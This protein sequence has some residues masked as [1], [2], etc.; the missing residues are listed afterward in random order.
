M[1]TRPLDL[2][3]RLSE[4]PRGG[5][6]LF[7][8]NVGLLALFFV[9]FGSRFVL[10]PGLAVD[11]ALPASGAAGTA[12]VTTD[13][14]IAVP[15][16]GIALVEGQVLDFKSLAGWLREKAGDER[17]K[18]LLVQASAGLPARD[19]AE[20]YSLAAEAGFTGVLI[21]TEPSAKSAP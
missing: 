9:L 16:A 21:A 18:R 15:A 3:S 17:R 11:F 19:L 14:V 1:I 2:A 10:S 12:A 20:I 7:Y 6:S 4:A 5:S 8:V 13:V